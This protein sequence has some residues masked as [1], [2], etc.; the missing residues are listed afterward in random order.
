MSGE[1][2]N[3]P[4]SIS[5]KL[6]CCARKAYQ[7]HVNGPVP[8]G[9][10]DTDIGWI[11][12]PD[13][14]TAGPDAIDAAYVGETPTE[15]IIAFRGTLPP[16]NPDHGQ[17]VLDWLSDCDAL[18]I[19]ADGFP[20]RVHQGFL[21]ALDGLWP[22]MVPNIVSRLAANPAKQVYITGHSKGGAIAN[23]AACRLNNLVPPPA[24]PIIVTTFAAARPGDVGFQ[25]G[26]DQAIAS[27][28]RY[29]CQDDI[30][31]HLV[32][33]DAFVAMFAKVSHMAAAMADLTP[34]YVSVGD[35]RFIDWSDQII[36]ES[37]L[38]EFKRFARLAELMVTLEFG[39]IISRHSIDPGSVYDR[40][41]YS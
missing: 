1:L 17:M 36:G 16:A 12:A 14:F 13:G 32:P 11:D 19:Q 5:R 29:E 20:G 40:A 15:I 4:I 23:L 24:A 28:I 2:P 10:D 37:T 34:D 38:L 27:S 25:A 26:Y 9:V 18:L 33:S 6:M 22:L 7:V 35:L 8:A 3:M 30:V 31:P 39:T 41:P 21:E